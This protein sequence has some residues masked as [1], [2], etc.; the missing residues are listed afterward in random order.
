[1]FY[2]FSGSVNEPIEHRDGYA[3]CSKNGLIVS[4]HLKIHEA[5][6]RA[7]KDLDIA[8]ITPVKII[9]DGPAIPIDR[10]SGIN[11]EV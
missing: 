6:H 3:T 9:S 10:T 5:Q 8:Y 1:M 4:V 11:T 2:R 7:F